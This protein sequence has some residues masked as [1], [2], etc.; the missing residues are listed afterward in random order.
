MKQ[1]SFLTICI[2]TASVC[3]ALDFKPPGP[4][5]QQRAIGSTK[6]LPVA[7]RRALLP[8]DNFLPIRMPKAGDWLASHPE[9]G[10]TFDDFRDSRSNRPDRRRNKIYLQ[11]YGEFS[12]DKSPSLKQLQG[13]AAA[14]FAMEVMLVLPPQTFNTHDLTTRINSSTGRRQLL[15]ADVLALLKKDLPDDAFCLLAITMKDLYPDPSWN[16]VFGQASLRARVGVF[17][18]AGYHPAFYGGKEGKDSQKL[19]LRRSGRVL[20]HE[21]AHMFGL[22]LLYLL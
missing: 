19:L 12:K 9:A 6:Q 1:V 7:F 8:E 18:F 21:T 2:L 5:E 10:Q 11:P 17:S 20:V 22:K 15:S 14:Y 16:Y 13:Y 3:L 4:A